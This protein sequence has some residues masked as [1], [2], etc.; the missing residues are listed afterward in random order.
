MTSDQHN[1]TKRGD[2]SPSSPASIAL[3]GLTAHE[4]AA[5]REAAGQQA[6]EVVTVM[7]SGECSAYSGLNI[8]LVVIAR[9]GPLLEPRL[10]DPSDPTLGH[11]PLVVV[12]REPAEQALWGV[13][14]WDALLG[15]VTTREAGLS[16]A[17]A[18]DEARRRLSDSQ[19]VSEFRRRYASLNETEVPVYSAICAG[20]LNKQ[21]AGELSVS[22]R[23]VEQRR[24]RVFE[25]MGVESAVPL[26]AMA[27]TVRTLTAQARRFRRQAESAAARLDD[28]PAMRAKKTPAS[29]LA[30]LTFHGPVETTPVGMGT[31]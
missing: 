1:T 23:T 17:A 12:C 4:E 9:T 18:I 27:A 15:S 2:D 21:I 29:R 13:V 3:L 30:G 25:K 16:L 5:W 8:P 24:K 22:V 28:E 10:A 31:L 19:L 11:V 7:T 6:A 20:R 26:A 14:A